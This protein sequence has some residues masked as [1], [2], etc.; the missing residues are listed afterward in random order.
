MTRERGCLQTSSSAPERKIKRP[1]RQA[2][3]V[4]ADGHS[5]AG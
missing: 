3:E 4:G 1:K 5:E 2:A